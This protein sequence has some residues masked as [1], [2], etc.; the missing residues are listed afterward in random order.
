MFENF[1]KNMQKKMEEYQRQ[2]EAQQRNKNNNSYNE[3]NNQPVRRSSFLNIFLWSLCFALLINYFFMPKPNNQTGFSLKTDKFFERNDV[4]FDGDNL[5]GNLNM[6]G[7]RLD[8]VSLKKYKQT[9]NKDS[10]NVSVLS[11]VFDDNKNKKDTYSFIEFGYE[12]ADDSGVFF[13]IPNAQTKWK[14]KKLSDNEYSLTWNN[15]K[16]LDFIRTYV[17]DDKHSI[18]QVKNEIVNKSGKEISFIPKTSLVNS[19]NIKNLDNSSFAGVITVF[20]KK[21]KSYKYL[22]INKANVI[23]VSGKDGYV[24]FTDNYFANAMIFNGDVKVV[25]YADNSFKG[26]DKKNIKTYNI[27][28]MK[29]PVVL[30]NGKSYVSDDKF[31]IGAKE[32]DLLS[33]ISEDFNVDKFNLLIDYGTFF[34]IANPAAALLRYLNSSFGSVG[35]AIIL[36]AIIMKIL[37]IPLSLKQT[38]MMVKMKKIAPE[39]KRIQTYYGDNKMQMQMQMALLYKKHGIN[40]FA[41]FLQILIQ[42][43]IFIALW[44]ALAITMDMRHA[45]FL[46][47]SDLSAKDPYYIL[48]IL[49]GITMW[50]QMRLQNSSSDESNPM[51]KTM[52]YMPW[53]MTAMFAMLPSGLILYYVISNILGIAQQEIANRVYK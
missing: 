14:Y 3:R 49:M 17:I 46:W 39:L 48:P 23:S 1:K 24:A 32:V 20:D 29:A 16:G 41:S 42:I 27:Q 36:F 25:I 8:S 44:R 18:I 33:S 37:L 11:S 38:K 43:P 26:E 19:F 31:F 34:F 12:A 7:N 13:D 45:E 40:P 6:N 50:I 30:E 2:V 21:F 51:S 35:I 9:V 28:V 5:F 10:D 53:I 47:L 22:K 15:G 4:S 52:K